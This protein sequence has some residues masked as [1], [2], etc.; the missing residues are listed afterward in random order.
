MATAAKSK[1]GTGHSR[2]PPSSSPRGHEKASADLLE[3]YKQR[4]GEALC[5]ESNSA[6]SSAFPLLNFLLE[7]SEDFEAERQNFLDRV[8]QCAVQ[9][10]EQHA[11]EW[12][13]KRRAEEVKELQKVCLGFLTS[14][15]FTK[16]LLWFL[17]LQVS[18][19]K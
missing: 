5:S 19:M 12:E 6:D 8:E 7:P 11:L 9:K 16:L 14:P 4:V 15:A 17:L 10:A 18:A 3:Y 2:Q 1:K 13:N